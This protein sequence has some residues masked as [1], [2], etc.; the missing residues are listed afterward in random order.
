[1]FYDPDSERVLMFSGFSSFTRFP[2]L[3]EVWAFDTSERSWEQISEIDPQ[4]AVLNY[5][6]D[7]ESGVV[8]ILNLFPYNT[9]AYDLSERT[10]EKRQPSEQPI[11]EDLFTR[12]GMPMAYDSESDRLILFGGG[13]PDYLYQDTW[14]YDYNTDTWEEMHP[15][16]SLPPRAIHHIAYDSESDRV[17]LWGGY[18]GSDLD[19]ADLRVWAYDYNS[20]TWEVFENVDGPQMHWERGGM[21]YIPEQDRFLLFTGLIL[22]DLVVA[23]E[24]WF[25]EFDKNTWTKVEPKT[26]PPGLAMYSMTY[27]PSVG[28]VVLFGGEGTAKHGNDVKNDIWLFDVGKENW[29]QLEGPENT[30]PYRAD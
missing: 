7:D 16:N 6:M 22:D 11:M 26:S 30:D 28:K 12:F 13:K 9:W 10:W 2:D 23:P 18:F 27:D 17:I 4:D 21:V 14:A 8:V 3:L 1:M 24:T 20:D 5:G 25:Y 15:T 29:S 19:D